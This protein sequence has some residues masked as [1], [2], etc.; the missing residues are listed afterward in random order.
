MTMPVVT[1]LLSV[2]CLLGCQKSTASK[3][4]RLPVAPAAPQIHTEAQPRLPIIRLFIGAA[5]IETEQAI[6]PEHRERG[7]MF[8]KT[9]GENEAMIFVFQ[10]PQRLG[11][12][13]KNTTVPLSAAY[14]DSAG[15]VL[16]I[17]DLKP[18]D[19]NP[20]QS[21]SDRIQYVLEVPQGWF[22]R[23]QIK[24]GALIRTERG[25]LQETYFGN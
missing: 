11:F 3:P 10:Q 15:K 17:H 22:E 8:R 20:A 13:M 6:R 9:M 23:R 5:E 21:I 18:L 12:W 4:V 2:G 16:E 24:P 25:T 7:M 14:I 1:M 19:E